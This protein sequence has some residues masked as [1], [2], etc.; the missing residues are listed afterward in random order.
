MQRR[1]PYGTE[2]RR[3]GLGRAAASTFVELIATLLLLSLFAVLGFSLYWSTAKATAAEAVD[4]ASQR[5]KLALATLLPRLSGEVRVPYWENPD[6]V[7][8]NSGSEWK[9]D[10]LGGVQSDSLILRIED[11]SNLRISTS[12]F[13]SSIDGLPSLAVDWWKKDGR[14]IGFTIQWLQGGEERAFHASWG[15]LLL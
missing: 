7:F 14:I 3:T 9:V 15:A 11:G 10:Y 13:D 2:C 12:Q 1:A 4:D 8:H 6:A 5:A